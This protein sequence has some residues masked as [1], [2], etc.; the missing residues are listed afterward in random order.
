M[1]FKRLL[2][3]NFIKYLRL[4]PSWCLCFQLH[5]NPWDCSC[6]YPYKIWLLYLKLFSLYISTNRAL[7]SLKQGEDFKKRSG[8]LQYN[9]LLLET[10]AFFTQ[11]KSYKATYNLYHFCKSLN[12]RITWVQRN[13]K[14]LLVPTPMPWTPFTR[15]VVFDRFLLFWAQTIDLGLK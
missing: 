5:R 4:I 11:G 9:Q 3:K 6:Y 14:D 15:A 10:N 8:N 13:L 12:S 2:N 7:T 1:T